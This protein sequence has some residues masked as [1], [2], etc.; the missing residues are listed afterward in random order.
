MKNSKE[1][2]GDVGKKIFIV[3]DDNFLLDMYAKKFT[4]AG[5]EVGT[6][7]GSDECFDKIKGGF[8]PDIFVFDLIM[9]K[10]NGIDLFKKLKN[11]NL[12]GPKTVN[13]ILTN[14]GKSSDLD[15]VKD[16][17]IDG[18]VVKALYTPSEVIK[19]IQEIFNKKNS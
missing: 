4:Q 1:T 14:Q 5:Y 9:P 17:G 15:R 6:A 11:A 7:L 2:N 13:I 18:Y 12:L 8:V 3:D 16:L 10:M 19:K